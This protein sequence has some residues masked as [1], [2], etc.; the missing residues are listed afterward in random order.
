MNNTNDQNSKD[1][2]QAV[3]IGGG[4]A[5]L[6]AAYK[7]LGTGVHPVVFEKDDIVGGISRTVQYKD[8]KF[9]IGGHRFFTKVKVVEDMWHEVMKEDFLLRNRS[10]RIMYRGKYFHYPMQP[11]NALLGLGFG[12]SILVMLSYA[13]ALVSPIWPER[14]FQDWVSNR[15]GAKL[16]N[17]F[18]KTYTEKVWGIPCTSISADWAAQRIQGFSVKVALKNALI[19]DRVKSKKDVVKTLIGSFHYPRHGPG[20]MW[21]RVTDIVR[22]GGGE[23][24]LESDVTKIHWSGNKVTAV[25]V[26]AG[27]STRTVEGDHFVST[28]PVRELIEK[29]DPPPP[30]EVLEAG[31][32]LKYR[33]FLTVALVIDRA[34]VFTDNWIYVHDESVKVGRLQNFK[35]WSPEMVPDPSKTCIGLE[36]FCF[37]GDNLWETSDD[38]LVELAS[39]E[40]AKLGIVERDEIEDGAVARMPKAYPVYDEHYAEYLDKVRDF[41]NSLD[42][43]YLVGRNGM[44]RYNNQ[45]HSMLSAMLA[46]ENIQGASNDIWSINEEGEYHEATTREELQRLEEISALNKSQPHVPVAE[47]AISDAVLMRI[48][49]RLDKA[50]LAGAVGVTCGAVLFLVTLVAILQADPFLTENLGLISEFFAGYTVTPGGAFLGLIHGLIWGGVLGWLFA[51]LHNLAIGLYSRFVLRQV[52]RDTMR[53]LLDYI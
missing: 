49:S 11:V 5:G 9:D 40:L 13:K 23:V 42:N 22:E 29:L 34:D 46:C 1:G 20:M 36:Y 24:E 43:L 30:E 10:S 15:F 37:E 51:Y 41:T 26:T 25:E 44:H 21:E 52:F 53:D 8:Y 32:G 17:I 16:F 28:M 12:Q 14:S 48:L 47:P 50:A 39:I 31:R 19:G 38:D 7:L 27:G 2:Q 6:T 3:I 33:D 45:D 35:N 4:P 18:F